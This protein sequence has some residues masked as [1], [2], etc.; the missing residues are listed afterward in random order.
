[1]RLGPLNERIDIGGILNGEKLV[2][3][4]I[5]AAAST[6]Q[7]LIK[8]SNDGKHLIKRMQQSRPLSVFGA[9]SKAFRMVC[10]T[11]P[12]NEQE[13]FSSSIYGW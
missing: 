12:F 5:V 1:M 6:A 9:L 4:E 3:S 8:I 2:H 13:K 11:R 7:L 10:L